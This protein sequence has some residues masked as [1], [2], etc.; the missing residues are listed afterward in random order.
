[1]RCPHAHAVVVSIDDRKARALPEVRAIVTYRDVAA[2]LR[3]DRTFLAGRARF[4]GRRR[5][6]T[7]SRRTGALISAARGT[8]TAAAAVEIAEESEATSAVDSGFA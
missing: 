8:A 4:V 6:E 5:G 7:S 1:V 2:A 3:G